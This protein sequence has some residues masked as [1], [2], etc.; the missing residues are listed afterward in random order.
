[1][2]IEQALDEMQASLTKLRAGI[3]KLKIVETA[4]EC[5]CLHKP[6][7]TYGDIDPFCP[8]HGVMCKCQDKSTPLDVCPIHGYTPDLPLN[9]R[10]AKALGLHVYRNKNFNN[11][12]ISPHKDTLGVSVESDCCQ[13]D[14]D[15][16]VAMGALEEYCRKNCLIWALRPP[17]DDAQYWDIIDTRKD[18]TYT[19]IG[20]DAQT[21]P[22]AICEA[23]VKHAEQQ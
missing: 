17:V 6:P 9:A 11:W 20:S 2:N 4:G 19:H 5:T 16:V 10:V 3:R 21:A 8:K 1:M 12:F 23:I 13:Y 7:K 14:N 22:Q 15:L 18:G